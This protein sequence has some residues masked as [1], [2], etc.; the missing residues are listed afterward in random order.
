MSL[1]FSPEA[2]EQLAE[3]QADIARRHLYER[4]NDILDLIEDDQVNARYASVATR[5]HRSGRA[6]PWVRRGLACALERDGLG[7]LDSLHR[8]RSQLIGLWFGHGNT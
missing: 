3:L 2:D 5:T 4:M 8:R 6:C 1:L 7:E